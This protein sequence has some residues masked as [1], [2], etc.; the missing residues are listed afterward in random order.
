M[1][2][3]HHRV[4]WRRAPDLNVT[5]I[6]GRTDEADR[7]AVRAVEITD[8]DE[9]R[10]ALDRLTDQTVPGQVAA[11]RPNSDLEV[12]GTTVLSLPMDDWSMKVRS[13][14]PVDEPE[15]L[16]EPVWAGLIPLGMAVGDPE[17]DEGSVGRPIP[18]HVADWVR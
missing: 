4:T 6:E 14:P 7:Y 9:K 12:K 1:L 17:P 16:D 13:G 18:A 10:A 3:G 15:D 8:N 5:V 2:G 11:L